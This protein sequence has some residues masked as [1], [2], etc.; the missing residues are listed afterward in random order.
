MT[1]RRA[2]LWSLSSD[3][4]LPRYILVLPSAMLYH[5][6][7]TRSQRA[8]CSVAL[9]CWNG[10]HE[11]VAGQVGVS[12]TR[13]A[14]RDEHY[15]CMLKKE[16]EVPLQKARIR[17]SA[18]EVGSTRSGPAGCVVKIIKLLVFCVESHDRSVSAAEGHGALPPLTK[19]WQVH[20]NTCQSK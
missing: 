15:L 20:T 1:R 3:I 9:E 10:V 18:A 11:A 7:I 17:W 5:L 6:S 12:R 8:T 14:A 16:E 13:V 2:S 4:C 19:Q